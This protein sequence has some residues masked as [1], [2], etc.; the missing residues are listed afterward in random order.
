MK[1]HLSVA[2]AAIALMSLPALTFAQDNASENAESALAPPAPD[3][4]AGLPHWET[5][6]EVF[7]HPRC[8]NCHVGEDGIPIWSGPNYGKTRP[9]GMH[10]ASGES[11]IGVEHVSCPACHGASNASIAHGPPGAPNWHLAP[12]EMMWVGRTSAEVCTQ[13]KDPETNGGRTLEEVATHVRD[14]PLVAWGWAP[15]P[16]REP[17]PGTPEETFQALTAWITAGA[18]CPL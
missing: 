6:F 11:R 13:I 8:T 5:I 2:F 14:D 10:I 7:S 1:R 4:E 15:G 16:G 18:P 3:R 9:H 12:A 17:A